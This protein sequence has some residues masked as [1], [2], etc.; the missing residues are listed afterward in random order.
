MHL[1]VNKS[2]CGHT[3]RGSE[4]CFSISYP[5]LEMGCTDR[6][7]SPFPSLL[8]KVANANCSIYRDITNECPT[9]QLRRNKYVATDIFFEEGREG[10]V[11]VLGQFRHLLPH[12]R[13]A[14]GSGFSFSA[15]FCSI[16]L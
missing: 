6:C 12:I 8:K 11:Y 7:Y 2:L 13:Y 14:I 1:S 5:P 10:G 4:T 9:G 16:R 3:T 15:A